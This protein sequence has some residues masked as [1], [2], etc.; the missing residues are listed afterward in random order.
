[1]VEKDTIIFSSELVDSSAFF[2]YYPGN[3]AFYTL[4]K[5]TTSTGT[6][7]PNWLVEQLQESLQESLAGTSLLDREMKKLR[8]KW[9]SMTNDEKE[10]PHQVDFPSCLHGIDFTLPLPSTYLLRY[11]QIQDLKKQLSGLFPTDEELCTAEKELISEGIKIFAH[12]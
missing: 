8:E 5:D 4:E 6:T 2:S 12:G 10:H 3:K 9:A 1:M 7:A 11:E